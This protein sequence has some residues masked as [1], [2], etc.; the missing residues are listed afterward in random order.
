LRSD[1]WREAHGHGEDDPILLFFGR[2]VQE[3]GLDTF[4]ATVEALERRGHN[5]RPM[6]IGEGPARAWLEERLKRAVF[7]GHIDGQRLGTAVASAD[8]LINPSVTEAFG[9]VVLEAMASGLPVVSADAPSARALIEDGRSGLLCK[10]Q[11]PAAYAEAA[12]QLIEAP[13]RRRAIG[14]AARGA[15]AAY[16]WDAASAAAEAAYRETLAASDLRAGG[17]IRPSTR[18]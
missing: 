6:V 15:S 14:E 2:L 10:T 4:A 8:I 1:E 9:N 17:N 7:T 16:S 12:A 13:D 5:I 11:Q 18:S 3:K